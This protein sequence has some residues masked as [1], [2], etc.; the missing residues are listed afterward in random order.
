MKLKVN[1]K[2]IVDNFFTPISKVTDKCVVNIKENLAYTLTNTEDASVILYGLYTLQNGLKKDEKRQLN[3]PDIKKLCRVFD[4]IDGE[5]I[6]LDLNNNNIGYDSNNIKFVYHLLENGIIQNG[7][8]NADK[9]KKLTF[10]TEFDLID[11]K[12]NEVLKGSVFT[13]DTNKIYFYTK[14]KKVYAELTDKNVQNVDSITFQIADAYTGAELKTVLPINLEVFRLFSGL[15]FN[16]VKVKINT[17]L[18]VLMFEINNGNG[19]LKYIVS[20]LVK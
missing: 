14:D 8:V 17:K 10:D 3:I 13:S 15:S 19:L 20:A 9:I 6:D 1:K 18:K 12:V 4:C 16:K 2:S 11:K 7:V 5:D